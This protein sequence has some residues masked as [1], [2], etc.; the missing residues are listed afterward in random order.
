MKKSLNLLTLLLFLGLGTTVFAQTTPWKEAK[1][2]DG[3][4]V[5]TRTLNGSKFKQF[6]AKTT[7][8]TSLHTL[9]AL[10]LDTKNVEKWY[11]QAN[12]PVIL[13]KKAQEGHYRLDFDLPWPVDDR[14]VVVHW[15]VSQD[16][17]TKVVRIEMED[18]PGY[19]PEQKG[20]V[21]MPEMESIW[22]FTPLENGKV[23]VFHQAHVEPGGS[24]PAWLANST[25][26][27]GPYNSISGMKSQL[28]NY[29]GVKIPFIQE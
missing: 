28:A 9:V 12:N 6:K 8:T 4:V 17:T 25:V 10:A 27:D 19:A 24:V 13:D 2:K 21:R 16:P 15:A 20:L 1:N 29:K 22:Q 3:I 14:D 5:H 7:L 11:H 23:E 26:T 18:V